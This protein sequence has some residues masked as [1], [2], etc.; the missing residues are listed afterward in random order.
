MIVDHRALRSFGVDLDRN[1][2]TTAD[3]SRDRNRAV[4]K[5]NIQN[6]QDVPGRSRLRR[7]RGNIHRK[8]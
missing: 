1:R 7:R 6:L 2:A 5:E 8:N 4:P 3:E